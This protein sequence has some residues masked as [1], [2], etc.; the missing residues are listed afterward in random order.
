MADAV[1][2]KTVMNTPTHLVLHLTNI[3]DGTGETLVT[4]ADKSTFT[5][6]DGAEPDSLDLEQVRWAVQGFSS[7]RLLWDHTTDEVG[8]V[9]SGNGFDDF[10]YVHGVNN[11]VET[12]GVK[13]G[14]GAGGTGDLFLSTAGTTSGNTY[15]IT[16]VLRKNANADTV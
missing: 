10:R 9:L 4:K 16:L 14:R 8:M 1:T 13:D 7:V 15:D 11:F 5:A 6:S 12:S 3:S 2:V